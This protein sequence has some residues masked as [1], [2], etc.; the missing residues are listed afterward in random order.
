MSR[1]MIRLLAIFLIG[2]FISRGLC[3]SVLQFCLNKHEVV[4]SDHILS[5][6][7]R[8]LSKKLGMPPADS[9]NIIDYI[10]EHTASEIPRELGGNICRDPNDVKMAG[11][12]L[13][14]FKADG[15]QFFY[16]LLL[17]QLM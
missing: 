11:Y 8:A 14:A 17:I 4:V 5:E 7:R 2:A 10:S 3:K 15:F 16:Y 12:G 6:V 1:H 9:D 13:L